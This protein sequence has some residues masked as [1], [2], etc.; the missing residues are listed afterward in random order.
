MR[1]MKRSFVLL[2][3]VAACTPPPPVVT[4]PPPPPPGLD[5]LVGKPAAAVTAM[6]GPASLDKTEGPARQLQF[7]RPQC[8]LDVYLYPPAAGAAPVVRTA[9]ARKPDGARM[10]PGTCFG[11]IAPAAG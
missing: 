11:L 5:R 9:A 6:L 7:V 4:P 3:L 2:L 8:V 10:D 1:A